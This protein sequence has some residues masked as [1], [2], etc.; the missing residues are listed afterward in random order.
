MFIANT[1]GSVVTLAYPEVIQVEIAAA[2]YFTII[3]S[4]SDDMPYLKE[5]AA[6][7][8]STSKMTG[9]L[10]KTVV[11]KAYRDIPLEDLYENFG[12]SIDL[13]FGIIKNILPDD[14]SDLMNSEVL[15]NN[16]ANMWF[17]PGNAE[18][19][20]MSLEHV[21]TWA[22]LLYSAVT[23]NTYKKSRVSTIFDKYSKNIKPADY[24]KTVSLYIK[25]KQVV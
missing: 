8:V 20:V 9:M 21:P 18:T 1:L 14:K 4:D 15:F 10:S 7:R 11:D 6:A 24:A 17:G 22:A 19:M 23:D 3:S 16:I 25:S 2:L 12:K 13:L 5:I